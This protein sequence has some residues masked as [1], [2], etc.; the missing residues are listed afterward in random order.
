MDAFLLPLWDFFSRDVPDVLALSRNAVLNARIPHSFSDS[1][2]VYFLPVAT[3]VFLVASSVIYSLLYLLLWR[4]S[5]TSSYSIR[6]NTEQTEG[7][8]DLV[9]QS[10]SVYLTRLVLLR[11]MGILYSAAFL[12][13]AFQ[14]R[15]LFGS[16]G[17]A[18]APG[19]IASEAGTLHLH[20]RPLPVFSVLAPLCTGD[21]ALEVISWMGLML[22]LLLVVLPSS[23]GG[24]WAGLPL[25]LWTMYLSIV[26]LGGMIMNYGWE[27]E[28][29]EVG[30]L[31]IFL[32]PLLPSASSA[33][34]TFPT[35]SLVL[36]LLRWGTFRLMIG[37]GMSKIGRNSSDCWLELSCTETHYETQ[38][39][40]NALAWVFH[41]LPSFVHRGE[42]AMTFFEQLVLPWFALFPPVFENS[43]ITRMLRQ[44][45][46]ICEC[47]FQLCIVGTGNYAW[48]NFVGALPCFAMLDDCFLS[49]S[50]LTRWMFSEQDLIE[51]RAA[52]IEEAKVEQ[53]DE[54]LKKK[55]AFWS[56]MGNISTTVG[57]GIRVFLV[58]FILMKSV[59]PVKELF[60]PA[61]WLHFY[62]DYFFVNAQGVFGFINQHRVVLVL[63]TSY[64][65]L[66]QLVNVP[67]NERPCADRQGA[68][69]REQNGNP[70][71]C[72]LLEDYCSQPGVA[73]VCPVTCG[74][75]PQHVH[76][77]VRHAPPAPASRSTSSLDHVGIFNTQPNLD[78]SN[79]WTGTL[80]FKNLPG[81]VHRAPSVNSPYHYRFDWEVWIRTTA[82]MEGQINFDALKRVRA[83]GTADVTRT[84]QLLPDMPIP[85][86]IRRMIDGVLQGNTEAMGL[87]ANSRDDLLRCEGEGSEVVCRPPT[88]IR[89]RYYLYKYSSPS[90]LVN[91]RTW[92]SREAISKP[93]VILSKASMMDSGTPRKVKQYCSPWQRHWILLCAVCGAVA[94]V[95]ASFISSIGGV[96]LLLATNVLHGLQLS[97]LAVN[98]VV[99]VLTIAADYASYL[100][101]AMPTAFDVYPCI[102]RI[103]TTTAAVVCILTIVYG[104][105]SSGCKANEIRSSFA[106]VTFLILIAYF[107]HGALQEY[108]VVSEWCN[109]V[110][111]I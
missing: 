10:S 70:I 105:L 56:L 6:K 1:R 98:L 60:T 66:D 39:M 104:Q 101:S 47:F 42:V 16:H 108:A 93:S 59:A 65:P 17:L 15:A 35:S 11:G 36:W 82:S 73:D 51:A 69:A 95:R 86:I 102:Q 40:P 28:T 37:A 5:S 31:M 55:S 107:A 25:L 27:W 9:Q 45:C 61:P 44:F 91:N 63:E 48:I 29:L 106:S 50:V 46:F 85:S 89:A 94:T 80:E 99:I 52:V 83:L 34:G 58:V 53:G 68:V 110:Y 13:S 81:D 103:A 20:P 22:S 19:I 32:C 79:P 67:P 38:P 49:N 41:K 4:G 30:F 90:D 18:P 43:H 3:G 57:T 14:S 24:V 96:K 26:N 54:A 76:P 62:D 74:T 12:T 64:A 92:W 88:A 77:E 21:L 111:N 78:I 2:W 84:H 8:V 87:L 97:V 72:A 33:A 23:K 109:G 71:T 7:G 75:C 100:P